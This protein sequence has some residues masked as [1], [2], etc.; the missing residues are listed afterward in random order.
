MGG[1]LG[2]LERPEVVVGT[3]VLVLIAVAATF[4]SF[5]RTARARP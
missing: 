4:Y 2:L 1:L 5:V 3:A